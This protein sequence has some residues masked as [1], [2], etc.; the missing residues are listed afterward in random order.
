MVKPGEKVPGMVL[1]HGGGGTAFEDWVQLWV[2][3]GYAAI[4]MDTCGQV[5][6]GSNAHWVH[7]D[8]GGP[9]GWG[10]MDQID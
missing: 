3:R 2:Q 1:V 8:Q 4:A 6:V 10:G 7:D 9:P 5:P